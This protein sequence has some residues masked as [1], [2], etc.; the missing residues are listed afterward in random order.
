MVY[1]QTPLDILI[2]LFISG[3]WTNITSDVYKRD[4]I[5]ISRGRADEGARV[6][7]GKCTLTL[8]NRSGKYSP[9]NPMS[10]LYGQIGRN[11]PVRVSVRTGSPYLDVTG[12]VADF[13]S[14]PDTAA[15]DITGDLDLRI[16]AE[17]DWYATGAQVL[18]G[19]WEP[20]GNQKAYMLRLENGNI[21]L[22]HSTDGFTGA[23]FPRAL[24]ALP[25]RAALRATLDIDNGAGAREVR[26]YWAP[27]IAGPWTEIG[28][29]QT[30]APTT[31]TFSSTA[32]LKVAPNDLAVTVPRYPF[33]GKAYKA[34]VRNGIN[35]TVV[36][37]PDFTAQTV[38]AGSFSDGAG[39]TWSMNG[40]AAITNRRT[41]FV[42]EI[43]SWPARWDVSGKDV[44]T[45]VEAAGILRRLGQGASP[46][47]STL[48]RRIPSGSPLAY[49][50]ME[51]GKVA[52]QAY[53]PID[54]VQPLKIS[55]F[56]MAAGDSL[57][58]SSALP[59][60]KGG[61][62][63]F[64]RVPAP[65]AGTTQWHTE[66]AFFC[67]AGPT[68]ARTVLQWQGTG[69]VKR[70]QILL[71]TNGS[72][73][74]GYDGDNNVV[75]S[76]VLDLTGLGFFNAWTRWQLYAVQN[77]SNVD[78]TLR[79]ITIGGG[80]AAVT[81]SFAGNVG[82]ITAVSGP[83]TYSSDL[84]G[85][86]FGH[87]GVFAT[88]N[89]TIYNSA[90][91]GFSGDT[92][93]ARMNRLS[94]EEGIPLSVNGVVTATEPMGAQRLDTVLNLL[95]DAADT[96]HGIL[97]ERR[98]SIGLK[99]R[100]RAS[101][102]NQ[103]PALALDYNVSGHVA[104]PL[105]PVDDDQDVTN[106]V[107][108]SR[109]GGS[110]ARATLDAG[111]L[112]TL[113]PPSGVGR[114]D[115]S[116]TLNLHDDDQAAQHAG[117]LLHLGTWDETR[118]PVLRVDLAA[119]PSLIEA[120]TTLDLG[121]RVT[122]AH[123]PAWLPPDLIDLIAQGYTETLGH[124]IDWTLEFNCTPAGPWN[125]G[126]AEDDVYGWADTDGT[127]LAAAA[128]STATTLSVNVT[129]GP[130]WTHESD[131]VVRVGGEVMTVTAVTGAVGDT[132]TRLATSSWGTADTG[133]TW[134]LI[135]GST[136]DFSVQGA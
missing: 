56:D 51:D 47:Q 91:T 10:P 76:S 87:L 40:A 30:F 100:D 90:D 134:T 120:A 71:V 125:V 32:P 58:G 129:D 126:Y 102:Y 66:F 72:Q 82:R 73:V 88:A 115:E 3:A 57:P 4:G 23:F 27:S 83:A 59:A 119:A 127:V 116:V 132:F 103:T 9:K 96:D 13:A 124:P 62:K 35:G 69:T 50:P 94:T 68:I 15:L 70:W 17:A 89:T 113:S 63:L 93:G 53:S 79:L 77:G 5:H 38:G 39:R 43:S 7:P 64:G 28:D 122:V 2:E 106:D 48:R 135:G 31:A 1:P 98:S 133:E 25:R 104:P 54:G 108:V 18:I 61:A 19:K 84:D 34:E 37:N 75:T 81:T 95:E 110:S 14:T 123:P 85:L 44:Y 86:L 105:E 60:V 41:R 99:Y 67:Q 26:Y 49:W 65:P 118:Y 6:D 74:F 136:S 8:N 20:T 107:T 33:A 92:A 11:T 101:L 22:H 111:P 46:L 42:G 29:P 45:P 12:N 55:G 78:W 109:V 130:R 121:D 24:P 52:T 117:W 16:E 97:Y 112:S 114:Y 80:S 131:F 128:T 21:V 36:A